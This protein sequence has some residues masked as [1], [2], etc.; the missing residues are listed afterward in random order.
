MRSE[1]FLCQACLGLFTGLW[2]VRRA[3]RT[4]VV[5]SGL[6]LASG[7][8]SLPD[9][10]RIQGNMDAMV[11]YMGV[12]ASS[13]PV[14]VHSTSRM[15]DT[16]EQMQR[17]SDGLLADLQK[18]GGS[19]ERTIQNYSQA[20]LDNERA[21]IANLKG[22]RQEIGELKQAIPSP[23]GQARPQDQAKINEALQSRLTALEARLATIASKMDKSDVTPPPPR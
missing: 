11:H 14:M 9:V 6:L 4:L 13:M 18:K 22:I 15:A 19:A 12:M 7:C 21:M 5:A 23:A 1:V 20:L 16:A 17:K 3:L 2:S 10:N 8:A